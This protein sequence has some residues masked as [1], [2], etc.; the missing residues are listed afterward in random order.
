MAQK[1]NNDSRLDD[2]NGKLKEFARHNP[3]IIGEPRPLE[4]AD[5]DRRL[6][7]LPKVLEYAYAWITT[8]TDMRTTEQ[9]DIPLMLICGM[10]R[11]SGFIDAY[12]TS[13]VAIQLDYVSDALRAR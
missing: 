3:T 5:V 7:G 11:Q 2:G 1:F 6:G 4:P 10:A 13:R 9:Q 8:G 12:A